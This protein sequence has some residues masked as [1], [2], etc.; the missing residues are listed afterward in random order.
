MPTLIDKLCGV[1]SSD[2]QTCA[3][4]NKYS[5]YTGW[6]SLCHRGCYYDLCDLLDSYELGKVFEPDLR[7]VKYFTT[8]TDPPHSFSC[9][10]IFEY[11]AR[12]NKA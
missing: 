6:E 8:Y 11:I 3:Y 4:C 9:K 10:K 5:E 1:E 12:I 7:I 2:M